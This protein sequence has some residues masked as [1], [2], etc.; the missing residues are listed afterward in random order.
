MKNKPN[1]DE[2]I[3]EMRRLSGEPNKLDRYVNDFWRKDYV[4]TSKDKQ[5]ISLEMRRLSKDNPELEIKAIHQS[6]SIRGIGPDETPYFI[7]AYMAGSSTRHLDFYRTLTVAH[8]AF[9][10]PGD[11]GLKLNATDATIGLVESEGD[12][13]IERILERINYLHKRD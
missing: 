12:L 11:R 8:N 6:P 9:L 13:R 3:E 5:R 4:F 1:A 7:V 2:I 10:H